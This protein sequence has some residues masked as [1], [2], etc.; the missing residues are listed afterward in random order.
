MQLTIRRSP[1]NVD[2][3]AIVITAFLKKVLGRKG[4]IMSSEGRG[5]EGRKRRSSHVP[6]S[7]IHAEQI[8]KSQ[9][10]NQMQSRALRRQ[11]S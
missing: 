3:P 9:A 7:L 5:E 6:D 10:Q 1:W 8:N 4:I 11:L 2:A